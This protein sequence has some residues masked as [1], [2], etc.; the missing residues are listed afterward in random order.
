[1]DL[2]R[3]ERLDERGRLTDLH[4]DV[5]GRARPVAQPEPIAGGI[6]TRARIVHLRGVGRQE[7]RVLERRLH[8]HASH[9]VDV[10]RQRDDAHRVERLRLADDHAHPHAREAV[11]LRERAPHEHVGVRPETWQERLAAEF[12]VRLV[13]E[14][15]RVSRGHRDPFEIFERNQAARRVVRRV[16]EDDLRPWRDRLDHTRCRKRQV[17][18]CRHTHDRGAG[19]HRR[20]GIRVEGRRG[21]DHLG[22]AQALP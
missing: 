7:G 18:L 13:H 19:R 5:V 17:R 8:G 20:I 4:E 2:F 1:V 15:H 10:E 3:R 16:E 21:H 11:R 12:D 14:D 9:H 6:E 22:V